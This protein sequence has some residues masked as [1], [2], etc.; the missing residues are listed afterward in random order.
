MICTEP[1]DNEG[2]SITDAGKVLVSKPDVFDPVIVGRFNEYDKPFI[3]IKHY[4]D[5]ARGTPRTG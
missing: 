2:M 4:E 1:P 3:W 5:G